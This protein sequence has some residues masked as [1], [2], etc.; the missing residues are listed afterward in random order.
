[1]LDLI[2]KMLDFSEQQRLEVGLMS[3]ETQAGDIMQSVLSMWSPR[4]STH[5]ISEATPLPVSG[6]SLAELWVNYLLYETEGATS[7]SADNST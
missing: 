1:V 5:E 3:A 2:S 4:A 6:N 7:A